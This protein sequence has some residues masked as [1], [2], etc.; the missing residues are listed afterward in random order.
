MAE[1]RVTF[2]GVDS[3]LSNMMQRMRKDSQTLYRDMMRDAEQYARTSREQIK[4]VEDQ[5]RAIER[6]NR[7]ETQ[8]RQL[9]A[10]TRFDASQASGNVMSMQ[11]GES[12]F[13]ESSARI[14]K[15]AKQDDLQTKYLRDLLE[16]TKS[17]GRSQERKGGSEAKRAGLAG[18]AAAIPIVGGALAYAIAQGTALQTQGAGFRG[19]TGLQPSAVVGGDIIG[20]TAKFGVSKIQALEFSRNLARM[21]GS[22][23]GIGSE[24]VQLLAA[25]MAL[26]LDAGTTLQ[27]TTALR[28]DVSGVST[29][30]NLQNFIKV[31]KANGE[32]K[33]GDF[34]KLADLLSIQNDL[35]RDQSTIL[36][37]V[38]A[39][40]SSQV[41]ASFQRVGGSFADTATMGQ[42]IRTIN[43]ALTNPDNEFKR[44]FGYSVLRNINPQASFFELQEMQERGITQPGFLSASMERLQGMS[45]GNQ[46]RFMQLIKSRLGLSAS[47]SRGLA[48][49]FIADPTIFKNI[50]GQGDIDEILKK[51]GNMDF[52]KDATQISPT[53]LQGTARVS[54]VASTG[55]DKA[56]RTAEDFLKNPAGFAGKMVDVFDEKMTKVTDT[57]LEKIGLDKQEREAANLAGQFSS[58][59]NPLQSYINSLIGGAGYKMFGNDTK[60][61]E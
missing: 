12:E 23:G 9:Q 31:M 4:I 35:T 34:S 36:E 56:L 17:Q 29:S 38:N 60:E 10:Q 43:S 59:G 7:I 5:I 2:T 37:N 19:M 20:N 1:K 39:N 46:E 47:Q 15:E 58:P 24:N 26:G 22:R 18:V 28:R 61:S 50:G 40:T 3:G 44:A 8:S 13:R 52:V 25:E 48:N 14:S 45:G 55:G 33:G 53:I 16:E 41:L 6:K 54:D 51:Y 57:L 11:R 49:A 21:Q 42:R 30:G 32:F 27:S